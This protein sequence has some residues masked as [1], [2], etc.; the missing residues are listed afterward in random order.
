MQQQQQQ[1]ACNKT[2]QIERFLWKYSH[3]NKL[4][5]DILSERM[6]KHTYRRISRTKRERKRKTGNIIEKLHETFTSI[7]MHGTRT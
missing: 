5:A 1:R 2:D 3:L 6:S 7:V 4:K